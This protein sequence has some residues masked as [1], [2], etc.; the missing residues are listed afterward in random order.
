M[1]YS[2]LLSVAALVFI[3]SWTAP[4]GAHD[5]DTDA[6]GCHGRELTGI[7]HCHVEGVAL[8]NS[9][10][11][12]VNLADASRGAKQLQLPSCF[13]C[14]D[15]ATIQRSLTALGHS[16]GPVDGIIGPRTRA[17]IK[18]YQ[19]SQGLTVDGFAT[20]GL[21]ARLSAEI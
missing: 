16:P 6:G 15:V 7:D 12:S 2:S 10:S 21:V 5:G 3:A 11:A 8:Q 19:R 13:T 18:S 1:S 20:Q 14:E 17:A 4:V 9:E